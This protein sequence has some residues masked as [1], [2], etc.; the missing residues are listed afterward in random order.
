MPQKKNRATLGMR[1]KSFF[2]S[3]NFIPPL[4]N[5]IGSGLE[6]MTVEE[7]K[8]KKSQL[9]AN[10]GWVY[11]ANQAISDDAGA[12]KMKLYKQ[13]KDGDQEEVF[14]HEILDLI[15][16][17]N[18]A[19]T[20]KQFW[21]LYQSYLNLTGEAYILK[22]DN[23]GKPQLDTN[24]LPSALFPIPSHLATFKIG[25]NSWEESIIQFNGVDY[26]INAILRDIN[27]DP[28]NPYYGMSIVRKAS[29][30]I[31]TD[32]QMK[33]WNNKLFQN[34]ARPGVV[35]EVPD[36]M[37]DE[38]YKR[39][40][41]EFDSNYSG[42]DNTFKRLI[43]EGGA[44]AKPF[45]LNT[46]DLDFLESK[47]FSR[48]EILAMFRVSAS[49]I[50]IT[51]DVNR[52]NAEAQEYQYAKRLIKPRLQQRIDFLNARFIKPIYGN[53]FV[54]SFEEIVP[55]DRAQRL[56]EATGSVNKWLTIDEVR[57]LYGYEPLPDGQGT[58][59][60]VP[61]NQIPLSA[62]SE[63]VNATTDTDGE[64]DADDT[65]AGDSE[66]SKS[67]NPKVE[68]TRTKEINGELKVK[69]YTLKSLAY[70]RS[71]VRLSRKMFNQQKAD[72]LLWLNR[73]EEKGYIKGVD[74][75]KKD[76]ADDMV[77]WD[78][79]KRQYQKDFEKLVQTIIDE[80]G[81]EAY[82]QIVNDGG[83]EPFAPEIQ[84][85]VQEAS[86]RVAVGVNDETQK[87]IRA[88]LAQGLRDNENVQELSARVS[89]V[90]GTAS[91]NRAY[92]IALT[93][94]ATAQNTADVF[95]WGQTGV[96]ESKEWYTAE[97][98][99]V[100]VFCNDMNTKSIRLNETFFDKGDRQVIGQSTMKLD[101]RSIGEPPL[102]PQCRCVLLPV[103]REV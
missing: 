66:D 73:R 78:K 81:E 14:E 102:H 12:V 67:T 59:L 25:K 35:V 83:F 8:T 42:T 26:P 37:S 87:Q 74:L 92:V 71:M 94:S 50:G 27:P 95:A 84:K 7:Y 41:E 64:E 82:R 97:D 86:L 90:F 1:I 61:V 23:K 24:K 34:G 68:D 75:R 100:C 46:Q 33:R 44:K 91:T 62:I 65:P 39:F 19:L 52:A 45:M 16:N 53:E 88:T 31:D 85:Y 80:I 57:N 69:D 54:L 49:S 60:Y 15:N 55:E 2:E 32:V 5:H 98:E 93:E 18:N 13:K 63:L 22:L 48:D 101:Y 36:R 4:E 70:E 76:W 9:N 20:S 58:E 77:D 56:S 51:E 47:K 79:Y 30:T 10:I 40:K 6:A 21:S 28:E 38:E 17:P 11:T 89:Q 3:G 29:L 72:A 96:V 43:L 99:R 103:L